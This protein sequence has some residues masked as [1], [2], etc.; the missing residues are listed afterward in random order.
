VTIDRE[1][2]IRLLRVTESDKDAEVL[3]AIRKANALLRANGTDWADIVVRPKPEA[4]MPLR[5]QTVRPVVIPMGY[6][7]SDEMRTAIRREFPI[8]LI[9]FPLW[10]ALEVLAVIC[11]NVYWNRNGR[12]VVLA[13][14][15][16]CG[17]GLL[18]WMATGTYLLL[19]VGS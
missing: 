2:L 17:L 13:S 14:W 12:E 4:A 6:E 10:I 16:L 15:S 19:M 18:T 1:R 7:R 9:F 3:V 8:T 5:E 11:P